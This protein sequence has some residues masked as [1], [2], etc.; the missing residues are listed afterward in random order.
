[1]V[2]GREIET[3]FS[4]RDCFSIDIFKL[5]GSESRHYTFLDETSRKTNS[6]DYYEQEVHY[7]SE[8]QDAQKASVHYV[9]SI[10]PES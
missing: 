8:E 2:E 5:L 3:V 10:D 6:N 7:V 4:F 1:M 9:H